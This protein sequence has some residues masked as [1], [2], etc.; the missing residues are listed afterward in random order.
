MGAE[1][2]LGECNVSD[3]RG[4]IA[5]KGLVFMLLCLFQWTVRIHLQ[6]NVCVFK[7]IFLDNLKKYDFLR[8]GF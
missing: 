5:I 8:F 3:I 4:C 7:Y 1:R 2:H 6:I